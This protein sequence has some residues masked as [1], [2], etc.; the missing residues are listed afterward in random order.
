MPYL[1]PE[2][3]FLA[4]ETSPLITGSASDYQALAIKGLEKVAPRELEADS[5]KRRW[6]V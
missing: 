3:V 4:I 6:V 5:K 1:Q 2:V